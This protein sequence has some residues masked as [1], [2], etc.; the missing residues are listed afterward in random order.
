MS[1]T[2]LLGRAQRLQ[3]LSE[4]LIS[5]VRQPVVEYP[6][7]AR[8]GQ[9][10]KRGARFLDVTQ[11]QRTVSLG[12]LPMVSRPS[13]AGECVR[14]YVLVRT[15]VGCV[16]VCI[17]GPVCACMPVFCHAPARSQHDL[18]VLAWF[19]AGNALRSSASVCDLSDPCIAPASSRVH[20]VSHS[21]DRTLSPM[22]TRTTRS[23]SPPTNAVLLSSLD[24]VIPGDGDDYVVS[25]N[26]LSMLALPTLS[27]VP[28]AHKGSNCIV[29]R[30]SVTAALPS[31][32]SHSL[33][34]PSLSLVS[35]SLSLVSPSLAG[36]TV[37]RS[38][39]SGSHYVV[40]PAP[41][42]VEATPSQPAA[43][44]A[45]L[46]NDRTRPSA[47]PIGVGYLSP[48]RAVVVYGGHHRLA[49]TES[50]LGLSSA[51]VGATTLSSQVRWTSSVL[52]GS[53]VPLP[54]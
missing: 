39:S 53:P 5:A 6:A 15:C 17:C 34:S 51:T 26:P 37:L 18:C 28:V 42:D 11:Q 46:L 47:A 14:V 31:S 41:V 54:A 30:P 44:P 50:L 3:Q 22:S 23:G 20:R 9:V 12:V 8:L 32:P 19:S 29:T 40:L 16:P 45:A 4:D 25:D 24:A 7:E 27:P 43:F 1:V 35:P 49:S 10:D 2:F 52:F 33:V 21:T 36:S 38:P 13:N 48:K